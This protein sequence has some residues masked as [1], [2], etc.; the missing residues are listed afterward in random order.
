MK[1]RR[2][3][4]QTRAREDV[5]AALDFY[6]AEAGKT[7]AE[8]FLEAIDDALQHVA[9]T[10]T[11]GSSRLGQEVGLPDLRSWRL[12]R[13]PYLVFY[14]DTGDSIVIWR[15]L[16]MQRDLPTTLSDLG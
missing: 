14:Y 8:R 1:P 2:I 9:R 5:R 16:H 6:L 4:R 11:A 12:K 15:V 10:P 3:E 13:F 7:V